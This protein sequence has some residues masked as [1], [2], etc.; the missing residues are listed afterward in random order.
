M[1]NSPAVPEQNLQDAPSVYSRVFGHYPGT[2]ADSGETYLFGPYAV[3]AFA[4]PQ[5]FDT[6][7]YGPMRA[8][9]EIASVDEAEWTISPKSI[10]HDRVQFVGLDLSQRRRIPLH[11]YLEIE[12]SDYYD[13]KSKQFKPA[14]IKVVER[15]GSPVQNQWFYPELKKRIENLPPCPR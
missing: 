4:H 11:D 2:P 13:P 15:S 10:E 3:S 6:V 12:A 14:R 8:R 1:L 9:F 5:T 7:G